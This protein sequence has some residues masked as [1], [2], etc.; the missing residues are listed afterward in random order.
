MLPRV[1]HSYL[2]KTMQALLL[3]S[4]GISLTL[5]ADEQSDGYDYLNQLRVRADMIPFTT[6]SELQTAAENHSNY[7]VSISTATVRFSGH[8]ENFGDPG[9]TGNQARDRVAFAGY[10]YLF[11][12]ENVSVGQDDVLSS[13]DDLMSA[14]YHRFGFFS[15]SFD[16]VGLGLAKD[17]DIDWEAYTYNMGNS[18]LNSL[19]QGTSSTANSFFLNIC[20]QDADFRISTPDKTAAEDNI[21]GQ[22]PIIVNWPVQGD[23]D[24][25]PAFFE[26]SPDPLPDLSVSGYPISLQFNP[27]SFSAVTINSFRIFADASGEEITNTRLLDQQTDPNGQFSGLQFA[28][29]PLERLDWH[30]VYR[31]EVQYDSNSGPGSLLWKFATR[32]SGAP[33]YEYAGNGVVVEIP[34][35]VTDFTFYIPP[36]DGFP[37]IGGIATSFPADLSITTQYVDS[38]TLRINLVG[39]VG[40][41]VDFSLD[42]RSFSLLIGNS[43]SIPGDPVLD[44][45]IDD[46]E[47]FASFDTSTEILSIPL[48]VIDGGDRI[49]LSLTLLDA[50]ALTFAYQ[51]VSEPNE[52]VPAAATFTSSTL[53]LEI[54]RVDVGAT[55]YSLQLLLLDPVAIVLQVISAE[56]L[57]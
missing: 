54:P 16:E 56:Q 40:Q 20:S 12:G 38:N 21:R 5:V 19:C 37:T 45:S 48:L 4:V 14:I 47:V 13:L 51:G 30:A 8:F 32:S 43:A 52:A 39:S 34:V 25:P 27:L 1:I 3:C 35:N 22:N 10:S 23:D 33:L 44:L 28:L 36:E 41:Q 6:N 26:E 11:V 42:G 50:A 9:F 7:L 55:Q 17:P 29:Y 24:V 31:V 49:G 2:F 18:A 57:N 15:F 46:E 53:L